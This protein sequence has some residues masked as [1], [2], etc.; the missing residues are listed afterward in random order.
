[1]GFFRTRRWLSAWR[2]SGRSGAGGRDRL[3]GQRR[4]SAF[5]SCHPA[6]PTAFFAAALVLTM[7]AVHPLLTLLSLAPRSPVA[8]WCAVRARSCARFAGKFPLSCWWRLR[9]LCSPRPDPRS[10]SVW[11]LG[12]CTQKACSMAW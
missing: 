11:G 4:L 6:V 9:T 5:D 7:A 3:R 1:M 2:S 8:F 12:L 10:F